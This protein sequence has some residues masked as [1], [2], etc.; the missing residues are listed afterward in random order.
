MAQTNA[1]LQG[2][3]TGTRFGAREDL[4][5]RGARARPKQD[6]ALKNLPG[7]LARGLT[8]GQGLNTGFQTAD[9]VL[10]S[11]GKLAPG[12]EE[13]L[14][15]GIEEQR[16]S[17]ALDLAQAS[18]RSGLQG[19]SGSL[20]IGSAL[21]AAAGQQQNELGVRLANEAEA[22]K[23]GDLTSILGGL[24]VNPAL[25]LAGGQQQAQSQ[26]DLLKAQQPSSGMQLAGL[27]AGTAGAF[28]GSR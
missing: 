18:A 7:L 17:Q 10:A 13:G 1:G 21:G 12:V 20:A 6:S 9:E 2:G 24:F 11:K 5:G 22:R 16:R 23:R 28:F 27:A 25:S 4:S 8:G 19:S 3:N 14:R 26:M 15:G